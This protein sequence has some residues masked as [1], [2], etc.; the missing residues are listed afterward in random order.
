MT[1]SSIEVS[2]RSLLLAAG[3]MALAGVI[4]RAMGQATTLPATRPVAHRYKVAA[5]DW[6]TARAASCP[7]WKPFRMAASSSVVLP[8]PGAPVTM[9]S[10]HGES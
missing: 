5:C 9:K 4:G 6:M 1:G 7:T 3:G 8:A 2:R 10:R